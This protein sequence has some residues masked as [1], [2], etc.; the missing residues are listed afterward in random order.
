MSIDVDI[1]DPCAVVQKL[2]QIEIDL[3]AGVQANLVRYTSDNGATREV[4]YT[5]ANITELR[6]TIAQYE[7]E[8]QKLNGGAVTRFAMRA[9]GFRR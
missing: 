9:G 4:R 6:K 3:V 5:Q 8:C 2:K 7:L 1:T